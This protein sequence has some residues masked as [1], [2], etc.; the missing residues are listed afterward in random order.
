MP[1]ILDMDSSAAASD[2]VIGGGCRES[3]SS[4]SRGPLN[5]ADLQ[6]TPPSSS[7]V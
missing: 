3:L 1:D 7:S 5:K 2:I 6:V 4:S